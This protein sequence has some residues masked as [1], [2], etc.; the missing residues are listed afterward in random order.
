MTDEAGRFRIPEIPPGRYTLRVWHEGWR[1]VG[2]D[3]GRPRFSSPVILTREVS[4][5]P[6]QETAVDFELSQQLAELA[7][8]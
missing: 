8:D 3:S 4:V 7:G 2:S 5:S 1:V 6:R